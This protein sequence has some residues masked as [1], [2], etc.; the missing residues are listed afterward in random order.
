MKI[1]KIENYSFNKN[2]NISELCK[3]L[4]QNASAVTA[5]IKKERKLKNINLTGITGAI[6]DK[7][8]NLIDS[9]AHMI[10]YFLSCK[11]VSTRNPWL[12]SKAGFEGITKS[13]GLSTYDLLWNSELTNL[14]KF[15]KKDISKEYL[16]KYGH[17]VTPVDLTGVF[18]TGIDYLSSNGKEKLVEMALETS[19]YYSYAKFFKHTEIEEARKIAI[20][21]HL[22]A[23]LKIKFIKIHRR[24]FKDATTVKL[25]Q[26]LIKFFEKDFVRLLKKF[27]KNSDRK[28]FNLM[29]ILSKISSSESKKN[30]GYDE[31]REFSEGLAKYARPLTELLVNQQFI[32]D[33]ATLRSLNGMEKYKNT[34]RLRLK[35]KDK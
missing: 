32:K 9:R 19:N 34:K 29:E 25:D 21:E 13:L 35:T 30:I 20:E 24:A 10:S 23:E 3:N 8:E 26:Q 27:V 28:I 2:K 14:E 5:K 33:D 4:L 15:L 17:K 31:E 1:R 18:K 6:S 11:I 22:L 12:I 7:E 16:E